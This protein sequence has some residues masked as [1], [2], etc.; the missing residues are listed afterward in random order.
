MWDGSRYESGA[1]RISGA[2]VSGRCRNDGSV[3]A[4]Y[5]E[6]RRYDSDPVEH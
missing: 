3:L 1:L 2:K 5:A 6:E 4:S